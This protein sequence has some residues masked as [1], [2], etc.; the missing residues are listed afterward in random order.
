[1]LGSEVLV[2]GIVAWSILTGIAAN[3]SIR[4][5]RTVAIDAFLAEAGIELRR[6]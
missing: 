4:T 1:M 2:V 3:E 6:Q 5:G